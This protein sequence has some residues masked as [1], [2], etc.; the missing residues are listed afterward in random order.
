[1][2]K[3]AQLRIVTIS[4][5]ISV[6]GSFVINFLKINNIDFY[7]IV[8]AIKVSSILTAWWLFYF[9]IGWKIPFIK[10]ILYRINLQGTWFGTYESISIKENKEYEGRIAL[11]IKQDFLN[12]SIVSF[13]DK[14]KNYSFSEELK[15]DEKSD[16]HELVYVYSQ[17]E[18][19]LTD[20]DSRNGASELKLVCDNTSSFQRLE[21][22]FWTSIGSK[23]ILK[24]TKISKKV[25]DSFEEAKK[26]YEQSGVEL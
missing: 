19:I 10:N 11:R 21:G 14:F 12:L 3:K 15:Y 9:K 2:D 22:D 16:I 24:V 5:V 23:G 25:V 7:G 26:V 13:T 17:K 8:N 6:T 1:M 18:N 4:Y 20:R